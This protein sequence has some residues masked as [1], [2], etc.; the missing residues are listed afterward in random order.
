MVS[1]HY[2]G[3]PTIYSCCTV[4]F[5]T[6]CVEMEH[7]KLAEDGAISQ[8]AT[9]VV[10]VKHFY[11]ISGCTKIKSA[12]SLCSLFK[13]FVLCCSFFLH[14][15][16]QDFFLSG[17]MTNTKVVIRSSGVCYPIKHEIH[18]WCRL[19]HCLPNQKSNAQQW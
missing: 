6:R 12:N 14:R 16:V 18:I 1:H 13:F 7:V 17:G 11:L 2:Y 4:P 15:K 19:G 9:A 10:Q 3:L 8:T 5:T